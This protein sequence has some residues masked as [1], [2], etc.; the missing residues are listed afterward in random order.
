MKTTIALINKD[1]PILTEEE[2]KVCQELSL[3]LES[4]EEVAKNISGEVYETG[5][6]GIPLKNGLTNVC[7]KMRKEY[8]T[9]VLLKL[10]DN[11]IIGL[12]QGYQTLKRIKLWFFPHFW[13]HALNW[14]F[15]QTKVL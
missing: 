11:L 8:F 12:E 10:V 4:F 6:Q 5:S 1:L 13:I 9:P 3:F 2:W 14:P 7:M 15:L